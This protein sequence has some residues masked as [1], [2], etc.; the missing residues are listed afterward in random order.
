MKYI[1]SLLTVFSLSASICA[2][3]PMV[4]NGGFEK[5][6]YKGI[7][8][9]WGGKAILKDGKVARLQGSLDQ[10]DFKEGKQSLKLELGNDEKTIIMETTLG[11]VQPGKVFEF[12]FWCKVNG[13]CRLIIRENHLTP[14]KK[15][16]SE[17]FKN[18]ITVNGPTDWKK[19][20]AKIMTV[21]GDGILGITIFIDKGPG[22]VW[23]DDFKIEEFEVSSG[24]EISFRMSP[25]Y[26][27]NENTF[28][29]PQNSSMPIF[30]TCANKTQHKFKNPRLVFEIPKKIKLLSCGY[31]AREIK[32]AEEFNKNGMSYVRYEFSM[33]VPKSIMRSPDYSKTAYN[34]VI[35]LLSS[36]ALPSSEKYSCY[37]YYKDD[38]LDCKP[39]EFKVQIIPEV[40][41][42]TAPKKFST[43]IH[44]ATS[45][46]YYGSPLK[47]FM[48]FYKNSG[49]NTIYLPDVLRAGSLYPMRDNRNVGPIF[50]AAYSA[51]V[52][53]YVSTNAMVNGYTLR[54]TSATINAPDSVKI[55]RANG[56]IDKNAFDPAYMIRKGEWYAKGLN[57]II[58]QAIRFKAKGI[59]INWEPYMFIGGGGSFTELSLKDFA[60]FSG[61][62]ETIV[63][64]TAPDKL[65]E[66][67]RD[68]FYK[69]QSFQCGQA[70]KSMM[71]LIEKRCKEQNHPLEIMLCTGAQLLT[72]VTKLKETGR[73]T[74]IQH[75][76]RTF[77]AEDWLKYFGAVSS[78]YYV[79]FRS[80]DYLEKDNQ[81]LIDVGYRLSESHGTLVPTSHVKTL[82]E[83]ETIVS[84]LKAQSERDNIEKRKYIHLSQNLQAGNWVVKPEAIS[85]QMLATFI[86]GADGVDLYFFPQGYDGTYWHEAA[87][88]NSKIAMFEDFIMTGEQNNETVSALALTTLFNSDEADFKERLAIRNFEKDGKLLI[89][90]CNFD[91]LDAVPVKL[92]I[93]RPD[94]KY[95]LT[96]PWL[97]HRFRTKQSEL[98]NSKELKDIELVIPPMTVRFILCSAN[99]DNRDF[100]DLYLEEI[101]EEIKKNVPQLNAKFEQRLKDAEHRL[102]S[103][104]NKRKETFNTKTFEPVN[105]SLFKTALKNEDGTY[106]L[107]VDAGNTKINIVPEDGAVITK[108]IVDGK[109][110]VNGKICLNR[111]YLPRLDNNDINGTFQLKSQGL[112]DKNLAI[113]FEH[114]FSEITIRKSFYFE[115]DGKSFKVNCEIINNSK[116]FQ[117]IGFWYWNAFTAGMWKNN[118]QLEVGDKLFTDISHTNSTNYY[119]TSKDPMV[120]N[121]LGAISY[122]NN[123]GQ[124]SFGL[125]SSDSTITLTTELSDIAGFLTWAVNKEKFSTL[126][127]LFKTK[128]LKQNQIVNY[129]LIYRF[130]P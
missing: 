114:T 25:G 12:S 34:S 90:L 89:A 91:Y 13:G 57:Q 11:E 115:P 69:F 35:P 85:L 108:W 102:N 61:I 19:Y 14:E 123:E 100:K 5:N 117:T 101:K 92:N 49:F 96:A 24:D 104:N 10:N 55:K 30:L 58:D 48:E 27:I 126:E 83:V 70:M 120:K 99:E 53:A 79:Y 7:P 103:V 28:E 15:W 16:R 52:S 113:V 38:A 121:L 93:S 21:P 40:P 122:E 22:E 76:R 44:S 109:D 67:Y 80:N 84:Y 97:K 63:L 26:Y 45:I 106:V 41:T 64:K 37:I 3:S 43:G 59:W 73:W 56:K 54:Y 71:E 4:K 8:N 20:T 47:R 2:N 75:Y 68:E 1:L 94:G 87:K 29:L 77:M 95:T 66:Q 23:L 98:L 119:E 9:G 118:P 32:A 88:A 111:F 51:G 31:D 112:K 18:F 17:L 86:G 128:V 105:S 62:A 125:K 129:P 82:H 6:L 72:G 78:W 42:V 33:P 130:M 36:N 39:S 74:K 107:E 46:E 124:K 50:E 127:L 81:K 65:L 116:T 60:K 110:Q